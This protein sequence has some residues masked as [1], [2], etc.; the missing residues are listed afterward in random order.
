MS[1]AMV[2]KKK[3]E[4]AKL[5]IEK[6]GKIGNFVFKNTEKTRKI[7]TT[8]VDKDSLPAPHP[9]Y[10]KG[11]QSSASMFAGFRSTFVA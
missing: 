10:N 1:S 5:R 11:Y 6:I 7:N 2:V 3:K 8:F 9:G 4:I